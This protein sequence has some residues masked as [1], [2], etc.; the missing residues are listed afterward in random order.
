[1]GFRRRGEVATTE[2]KSATPT[3]TEV[4]DKPVAKGSGKKTYHNDA[5]TVFQNDDGSLSLSL[6]KRSSVEIKVGG[7]VV[8][9]FITKDPLAELDKS[10]N[11]GRLSEEK[12]EEIAKKIEK[13]NIV[14]NVTLVTE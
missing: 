3:K 8:T 1:M 11:D 6:N 2:T 13:A 12:A 14:G 9:G 7:K 5:I 4:K 10:V